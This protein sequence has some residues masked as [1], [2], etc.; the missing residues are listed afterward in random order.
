MNTILNAGR[1]LIETEQQKRD[2]TIG[3]RQQSLDE[4]LENIYI[5]TIPRT[6]FAFMVGLNDMDKKYFFDFFMIATPAVFYDLLAPLAITVVLFLLGFRRKEQSAPVVNT[7]PAPVP[8]E[9]KAC[10]TK[11]ASRKTS[12]SKTGYKRTN[13]LYR[14]RASRFQNTTR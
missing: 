3:S 13:H 11:T 12:G 14:L 2:N 6:F 5:E 4:I 7:P 9:K 1:L 10:R 8:E